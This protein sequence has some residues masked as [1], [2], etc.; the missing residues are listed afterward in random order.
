MRWPWRKKADPAIET[1]EV[2]T[3]NNHRTHTLTHRQATMCNLQQLPDTEGHWVEAIIDG[4][5]LK[6]FRGMCDVA[7]AEALWRLGLPSCY[8]VVSAWITSAKGQGNY[9]R[10]NNEEKEMQ[11]L[12][13]AANDLR[14]RRGL[15]GPPISNGRLPLSTEAA[16]AYIQKTIP[17]DARI[18][19]GGQGVE[20]PG[21]P[22][23]TYFLMHDTLSWAQ[24]PGP[25]VPE[26]LAYLNRTPVRVLQRLSGR[27]E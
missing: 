27:G 13:G 2:T 24:G 7:A 21:D 19:D 4:G 11:K 5:H 14:Q 6:G 12:S 3:T 25:G 8:S 10:Y 26:V 18:W 1:G 16:V 9:A 23:S 15:L 22:P 17:C 20:V